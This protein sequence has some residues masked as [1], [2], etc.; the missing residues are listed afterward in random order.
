MYLEGGRGG[1][2]TEEVP[3]L[4]VEGA[5]EPVVEGHEEAEVGVHAVRSTQLA[6]VLLVFVAPRSR[7]YRC[8]TQARRT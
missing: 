6:L 8:R 1:G 2:R 5:V 4:S 7:Q 3:G